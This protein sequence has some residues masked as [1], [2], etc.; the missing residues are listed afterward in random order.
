MLKVNN[1]HPR[2]KLLKIGSKLSAAQKSIS[3]PKLTYNIHTIG[4]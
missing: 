4:D 2:G 3:K 1:I